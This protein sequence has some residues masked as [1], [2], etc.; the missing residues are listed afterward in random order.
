M[1]KLT[2]ILIRNLLLT[3]TL[4]FGCLHAQ[5]QSTMVKSPG[6]IRVP[7]QTRSEPGILAKIVQMGGYTKLLGLWQK[8]VMMAKRSV[9]ILPNS[10]SFFLRYGDW[11]PY[12]FQVCDDPGKERSLILW[13]D[14]SPFNSGDRT[15]E[16]TMGADGLMNMRLDNFYSLN[17]VP[18]VKTLEQIIAEQKH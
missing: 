12:T 10:S 18:M 2:S 16:V 9:Y 7:S 4:L 13:L 17:N 5:A 11:R 14:E 8:R 15:I 3:L 6:C 1:G